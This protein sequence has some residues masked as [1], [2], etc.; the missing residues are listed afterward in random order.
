MEREAFHNPSFF[1]NILFFF[2]FIENIIFFV[3]FTFKTKN[4]PR[5]S[6]ISCL[7][8]EIHPKK[9]EKKHVSFSLSP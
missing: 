7:K 8:K 5:F 2:K 6:Q 3:E 1:F 4:F 9:I